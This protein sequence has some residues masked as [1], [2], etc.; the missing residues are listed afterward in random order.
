MLGEHII[1]QSTILRG[2]GRYLE[3][4]ACIE[5]NIGLISQF[6]HA[7]AWQEACYAAEALDDAERCAYYQSRVRALNQIHPFHRPLIETAVWYRTV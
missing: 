1:Q 5:K 7:T 4:M 6:L 3:A 2:Q